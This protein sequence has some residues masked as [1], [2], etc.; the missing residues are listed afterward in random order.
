MCI[1]WRCRRAFAS[2]SAELRAL[3][4]FGSWI[5]SQLLHRIRGPEP[6][7]VRAGAAKAC[8]RHYQ[9]AGGHLTPKFHLWVHLCLSQAEHGNAKYFHTYIDEGM[10]GTLKEIARRCHPST[11]SR[12]VFRRAPGSACVGPGAPC[13]SGESAPL[14]PN[15]AV[16]ERRSSRSFGPLHLGAHRSRGRTPEVLHGREIAHPDR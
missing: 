5:R 1:R 16:A 12:T 7:C 11:F 3:L 15:P 2:P 9:A 6:G 10:N 14:S 8:V 13:A 4:A